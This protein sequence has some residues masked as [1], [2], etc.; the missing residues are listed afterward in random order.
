MNDGKWIEVCVIQ[1]DID[2][3]ILKGLLEA[4]EIPVLLSKEGAGRALGLTM[5]PLGEVEILVPVSLQNEAALIIEQFNSGEFD[6]L[7]DQDV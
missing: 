5:G 2:A 3:E 6:Q 7:M 1:G 4:H